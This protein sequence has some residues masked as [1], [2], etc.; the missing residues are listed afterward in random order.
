[1]IDTMQQL[2]HEYRT[3]SGLTDR[4][5][6]K[7]FYSHLHPFPLL[8]LGQNPGGETDGTDL[9]ASEA[10][11]NNWEHDFSF[12]RNDPRY[13]LAGPM[14]RLL[15]ESLRTRSID[16][17]RQVP[18]TNVVF[19]R[20]RNTEALNVS[21]SEAAKE[22]HPFIDKILRIVEPRCILFVS[23]EAYK[24]FTRRNCR[25]GS[26]LAEEGSKLFTPNGNVPACVFMRSRGF[27]EALGVNV[28]MVMVGHPSKFSG[29][30]EWPAAT[31]SL[32]R[33][34]TDFGISPIENTGA[35]V[36]VPELP[37]YGGMLA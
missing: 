2:D 10:Y 20:S 11:F 28:D 12:F 1:M 36:Q 25:P 32:R 13:K 17:I 9:A 7:I 18:V 35:L 27:V 33:A 4:R 29:R 30:I 21:L 15:S 37:G 6:Y 24:Q 5:L 26:I 14:C 19:R 23:N 8:V 3:V 31:A 34:L 22:A 16:A